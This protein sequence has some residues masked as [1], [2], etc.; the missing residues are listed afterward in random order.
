VEVSEIFAGVAQIIQFNKLAMEF[1]IPIP[2]W[3]QTFMEGGD[4]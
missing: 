3:N 2:V 4:L 1:I